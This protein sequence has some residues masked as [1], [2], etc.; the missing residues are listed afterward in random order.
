MEIIAGPFTARR[1]QLDPADGSA[2]A[3]AHV[4]WK[5]HLLLGRLAAHK[6]YFTDYTRGC[7]GQCAGF[8]RDLSSGCSNV[9]NRVVR[10]LLA[11]DA[12]VWEVWRTQGTVDFCGILRL[13]EVE[14]GCTAKAHYMFFDHKLKDKTELLQAWKQWVFSNLKLRRVT[15]EVPANAFTLA[16]HAVRYLG[17]GGRYNYRGLPV[18]GVITGAKVLD[19]KELDMLILGCTNGL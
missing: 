15:I 7:N 4:I 1:L 13:S 5:S 8:C 17:F 9:K 14:P 6:H 18:E 11:K 10:A 2:E 19:G 12:L 16:R 3:K